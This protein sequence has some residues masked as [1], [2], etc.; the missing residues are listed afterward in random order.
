VQA[1]GAPAKGESKQSTQVPEWPKAAGGKM[2]FE[3]ASIRPTP[4]GKF[5]PPNFGLGNDDSYGDVHGVFSAKFPVSVYILFAYKIRPSP[6][7]WQAILS[8]LPK[9]VDTELFT[10]QARAAGDPTKDQMRLMMQSLLADRFKLAVHFETRVVPV[11]ALTLGKAGKTGPRLRP[12]A[13][14]PSCNVLGSVPPRNGSSASVL[15]VF[16]VT[17]DVQAM[18]IMPDHQFLY[19]SRDT[20][21]QLLATSLSPIGN[22]GL[23]VVDQTGL[24]GRFDYTLLFTPDSNVPPGSDGNTPL[25]T[26][27]TTFLEALKE[28]LGLK[29][30][31]TKAPV[32][33]LVVDH[34]ELPS[35]N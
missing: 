6:E 14:G 5:T 16:P 31:R 20:T 8:K 33:V 29:L 21:M 13:E 23:P 32:S 17:C 35:E 12:H 9:W 27:G 11:L 15:P 25:D 4:S 28:Q 18:F 2:A 30:T 7:E 22:L 24:T 10:I 1:Q 3:V 26:G 34:I 19:G